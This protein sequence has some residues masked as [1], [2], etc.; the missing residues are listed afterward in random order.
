MQKSYTELKTKLDAINKGIGKESD[1]VKRQR[2]LIEAHI[3][4]NREYLTKVNGRSL[5]SII[6]ELNKA[7]TESSLKKVSERILEKSVSQEKKEIFKARTEALDDIIKRTGAIFEGNKVKDRSK[8]LS[9][10]GIAEA[11]MLSY[12]NKVA[13]MV[14]T[15]YK[16]NKSENKLLKQGDK[17]LIEREELAAKENLT[18]VQSDRLNELEQL[19]DI[20]LT[21]KETTQLSKVEGAKKSAVEEFEI[22]REIEDILKV[23]EDRKSNNEITEANK[24]EYSDRSTRRRE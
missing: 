5:T 1:K 21:P 3:K 7:K 24:K 13:K 4:L 8:D 17:R 23:G 16:I 20:G 10:E 19:N 22:G 9:K 2:E 6:S 15:G 12:A 14:K 18:E 11:E